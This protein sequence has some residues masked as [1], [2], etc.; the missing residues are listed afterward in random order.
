MKTL[1]L[2]L[3]ACL[4]L[5]FAGC[6]EKKPIPTAQE[7]IKLTTWPNF[8][9]SHFDYSVIEIDGCEYLLMDTTHGFRV[10]THK[11]NCKN[12]IHNLNHD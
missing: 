10:V 7:A 8:S 5:A 11:G 9:G 1:I 4:I 12:P 6:E 2:L 3:N